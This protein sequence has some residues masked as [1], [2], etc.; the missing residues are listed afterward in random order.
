MQGGESVN[1]KLFLIVFV[2]EKPLTVG[3][4]QNF[5]KFSEVLSESPTSVQGSGVH[6]S[7]Y[8]LQP[9]FRISLIYR[10]VP[11]VWKDTWTLN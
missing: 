8:F 7:P 11:P 4:F 10:L 9:N 1:L 3:K 2:L 5:T 6:L